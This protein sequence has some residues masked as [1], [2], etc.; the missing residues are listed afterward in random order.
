MIGL[1]IG[2]PATRLRTVYLALATF[3]FAE[4]AQWVF[5]AW[6]S[7]T[8]GRM[9]CASPAPSVLGYRTGNRSDARFP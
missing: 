2:I 6:D 7:L 9:A 1:L 8:S 3:A 5:N 4:G